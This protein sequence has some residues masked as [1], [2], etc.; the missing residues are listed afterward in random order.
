VAVLQADGDRM[1]RVISRLELESQH[2]EFS[3]QLAEFAAGIREIVEDSAGCLIF[4]GADDVL[5]LLPLHACLSAARRIR[6]SFDHFLETTNAAVP[7]EDR[8]TLSAGLAIGHFLDPMEDL[9][10]AADAAERHAKDSGRDRLCVRFQPRSGSALSFTQPWSTGPD[11]TLLEFTQWHLDDQVSDKTPYDLARVLSLYQGG[12][13]EPEQGLEALK[14]DSRRVLAAKGAINPEHA[15]V[16][17]Q[18]EKYIRNQTSYSEIEQMCSGMIIA[19][20]LA[21]AYKQARKQAFPGTAP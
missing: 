17:D 7:Q 13:D 8:A 10:Q 3:G 12:W 18:I 20:R 14:A 5:A 21:K 6:D 19:R 2:R 15:K 9:L 1:G 11:R 16:T 4:A